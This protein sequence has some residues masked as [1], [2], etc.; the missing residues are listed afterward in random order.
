MQ[1]NEI[2]MEKAAMLKM[3]EYLA[4]AARSHGLHRA[5]RLLDDAFE[6]IALGDPPVGDRLA[7]QADGVEPQ[8]S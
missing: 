4:S 2:K 6:A 7:V 5:G 1:D 8:V 3:A